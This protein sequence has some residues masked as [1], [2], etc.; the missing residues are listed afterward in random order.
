MEGISTVS[1]NED[2]SL[3]S[4]SEMDSFLLD[5]GMPSGTIENLTYFGKLE[6]FNTVDEDAVFDGYTEEDVYLP[7]ENDGDISLFSIPKSQ[8]QL[9]VSGFKNSDGTYSIYP[10]FIRKT[11]NRLRN[12][13]F[14]FVLDNNNWTT[15]AG[16]V[17]LNI[18]MVNA[19]PGI[20]DKFYYD[21][22]S[23]SSYS[24]HR[25]QIPQNHGKTN[26]KHYEGH[27]HFKAKS[28]KSKVDKRIILSYGNDTT[29]SGNLSYSVSIG[30]FSVSYSGG[31]KNLRTTSE[32]LSW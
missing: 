13:T 21:R 23:S 27:A 24:G 16:N 4:E 31:G 2:D 22:P 9:K 15:V 17:G 26:H 6:I 7:E 29:S 12:D 32:T 18:H 14:S 30:I 25:F 10:S 11:K 3:P 8:L 28:K 19:T 20:T 1:A 5:L